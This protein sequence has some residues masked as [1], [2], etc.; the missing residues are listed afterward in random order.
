M[1]CIGAQPETEVRRSAKL[2]F[3]DSA[4]R[5]FLLI[6]LLTIATFALYYQVHTH[7]WSD[8]DDHVYVVDNVH[9]HRLNLATIW[10]SVRVLNYANWI[11]L[12]WLSHALDYQ[13]FGANPAGHHLVNVLVHALNAILV[14]WVLK[15]AT[16]ATARSFMVAAL[17]VVHPLNVEPVVWI[18]ER[19]TV[20]SMLF[21]LL[22]LAAY[23]WYAREPRVSRYLLV[24]VL[25]GLGLAAKSQ[26]ITL[27]CVLLLWDYWPLQRMVTP[28]RDPAA[29]DLPWTVFPQKSFSCLVKEKLPLLIPCV[30]DAALTIY[31][32]KSVR[33]G[34]MP[35]LSLRLKNA[36][37]SYWLYI[38]QAFWPSGMGPE[39]PQMGRFVSAWEIIAI[40][41]LLIA[42]SAAVVAAR[43][44]RYLPVG[45]FWFLGMLVPMV[46]IL[47][48]SQQ[49]SAD[50]FVYEAYL[51][52]FMIV[53]WGTADWAR[54]RHVS[55]A[56]LAGGSAIVLLAL[57]I[58]SNRQIGYWKDSFTLWKHAAEVNKYNWLAQDNVGGYLLDRGKPL[59]AMEH[60]QRG[61]A[62]NP[63]NGFGNMHIGYYEQATGDLPGAIAHYQHALKD[64]SLPDEARALIW[65]DMGVAYRNLGDRA[66]A[67][68]CF[69]R[70]ASFG[71]R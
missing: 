9:L 66:K 16:G 36:V 24:F 2:L 5:T 34:L 60:F 42:I 26:V 63:D 22:T 65:R 50:R 35:P 56:W 55:R 11:P 18:A 29:A 14:F 7:P 68:E 67:L 20:L 44:H 69:Q 54:Q 62:I 64:Q 6:S 19:K 30:F 47:Q 4:A 39:S 27:P 57:T 38:R 58:V 48:P 8:L 10:W 21:F 37:F 51:G 13:F 71:A 17:F 31:A 45:W 43:R 25:F 40:L 32:Q 41:A 28:W 61:V 46:G 12:S 70:S 53:C 15:R 49:G 33:I 52:I 23:R 59:E 3:T 1:A